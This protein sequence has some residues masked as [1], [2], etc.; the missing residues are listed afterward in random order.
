M[1]VLLI[2]ILA[3][4]LAAICALVISEGCGGTSNS[5]TYSVRADTTMT[6]GDIDK[7]AFVEQAN[8]ICRQ[9]WAI[10]VDN[11]H[12]YSGWQDHRETERVRFARSVQLS[13]MAGIDFHIFDLIYRSRAP[14]GEKE[15]IE[16]I[17]GAMQSAVE[18]GEKRLVP[19]WSV[20]EVAALFGEYNQRARQ[21]GLED[22]VLDKRRLRQIEA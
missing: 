6:V 4:L 20:D 10:I 16:A 5:S 2:R 15:E 17:I 13:L 18:R 19:I 12:Q 22:C 11:F 7:A 3:V 1:Q 14:H 21:Y 8:K 9:G